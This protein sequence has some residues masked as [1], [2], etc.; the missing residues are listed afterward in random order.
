MNQETIASKQNNWTLLSQVIL[1]HSHGHSFAYK[2]YLFPCDNHK[3]WSFHIIWKSKLFSNWFFAV[4]VCK[5][6][7][8]T[9]IIL[10]WNECIFLFLKG[11]FTS[12]WDSFLLCRNIY[13]ATTASDFVWWKCASYSVVF[14]IGSMALVAGILPSS[15]DECKLFNRHHLSRT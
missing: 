10:A 7:L 6:L 11:L 9:H 8:L 1:E 12:Q 13:S 4:K 14:A 3:I 5:F 2:L 15:N